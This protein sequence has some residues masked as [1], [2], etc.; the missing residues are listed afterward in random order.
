MRLFKFLITEKHSALFSAK[1]AIASVC[2]AFAC[3]SSACIT[4]AQSDSN[5]CAPVS[6]HAFGE[7]RVESDELDFLARVVRNNEPMAQEDDDEMREYRQKLLRQK[8]SSSKQQNSGENRVQAIQ[9]KTRGIEAL[10]GVV[11]PPDNSMAI[12]RQGQIVL[13]IN[14]VMMVVDTTGKTLF[15]KNLAQFLN[16]PINAKAKS[17]FFC[18]PRVLY[19]RYNDRFVLCAMTCEGNS[20]SAQLCIAFSKSSNALDGWWVYAIDGNLSQSSSPNWFDFPICATNPEYLFVSL[21]LFSDN[22]DYLQSVIIQIP[23]IACYRGDVKAS[24]TAKVW[25]NIEGKP[26]ALYPAQELLDSTQS[27]IFLSNA[28]GSSAASVTQ[29]YELD[30]KS[31]TQNIKAYS[32]FVPEYAPAS[33]AEQA[34]STIKLNCFD[35][36]VSGALHADNSLRYVFECRDN[37]GFATLCYNLLSKNA[38]GWSFEKS[39]RISKNNADCCHPSLAPLVWNSRKPNDIILYTYCGATSY[40]GIAARMIDSSLSISSEINIRSGDRAVSYQAVD[41]VSRWADYTTLV[42]DFGSG[43]PMVWGFAPYGGKFNSWTNYICSISL[44]NQVSDVVFSPI[45][46]NS[47]SNELYIRTSDADPHQLTIDLNIDKSADLS[48]D[49]YAMNG[50]FVR[51]VLRRSLSSGNYSFSC[52]VSSLA[53]GV[54]CMLVHDNTQSIMCSRSFVVVH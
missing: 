36:R 31:T 7:T 47:N 37:A 10:T 16:S 46:L 52:S 14:S 34:N 53:S 19:D 25:Y 17:S 27:M 5:L 2:I 48:F 32:V 29:L 28:V 33:Y 44:D 22:R 18:D 11:S 24:S 54:Y 23:S 35:Q 40:P 38:T 6:I 8:I 45:E 51:T 3:L 9:L 39:L 4:T 12:N 49:V 1:S 21:N 43:T 50:S 26:H 13:A 30:T 42:H 41:D 20:S 15:T